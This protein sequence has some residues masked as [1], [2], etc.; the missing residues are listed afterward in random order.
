[1]GGLFESPKA[2]AQP[3]WE[4]LPPEVRELYLKGLKGYLERIGTEPPPVPAP[5]VP[6]PS[7]KISASIQG[8]SLPAETLEFSRRVFT[9]AYDPRTS[10]GMAAV[11]QEIERRG[12]LAAGPML[13]ALA[14]AGQGPGT[15]M[16]Q[17]TGEIAQS[18]AGQ[19]GR[20]LQTAVS[21]DMEAALRA[22]QMQLAADL[23][24]QRMNLEQAIKQAELELSTYGVVTQATLQ[25]YQLELA[26]YAQIQEQWGNIA[27]MAT[28]LLGSFLPPPQYGPPPIAH[29]LP[30]AGLFKK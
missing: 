1:M 3:V 11:L 22:Q 2:E 25:R 21:R 17:A 27:Q 6:P 30:L 10:P 4:R 20:E 28:G 8:V 29:F 12:R 7:G 15:P 23:E 18:I 13:Q 9:P 14:M 19:V 5:T 16:A 26:R 24:L